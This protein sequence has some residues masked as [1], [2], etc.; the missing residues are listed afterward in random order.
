MIR[1]FSMQTGPQGKDDSLRVVEI[2]APPVVYKRQ[3][4]ALARILVN[5]KFCQRGFL[6]YCIEL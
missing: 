5:G 4:V 6:H 1:L 2:D 3:A